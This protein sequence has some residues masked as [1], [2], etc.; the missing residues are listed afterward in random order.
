[1]DV[2]ARALPWARVLL[3][4]AGFVGIAAALFATPDAVTRFVVRPGTSLDGWD[5]DRLAVL[6]LGSAVGGMTLSG[7]ALGLRGLIEDRDGVRRPVLA[8]LPFVAVALI[9]GFKAVFGAEH[10]L[11]LMATREDSLV[12][13]LTFFAYAVAGIVAVGSSGRFFATGRALEGTLYLGLAF[14]LFGVAG[15]EI[16]WG[17]RV[18][19]IATPEAFADNLQGELTLHNLPGIQ[20]GLND[21]YIAVGLF[22][23]F[24]WLLVPWADRILPRGLAS[25]VAPSWWLIGYFLPVAAIYLVFQLTPAAEIH[26]RVYWDFFAM[27]DQELA[28]L[29]LALGFLGLALT[30]HGRLREEPF[31]Q[32]DPRV[33]RRVSALA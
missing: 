12:E 29:L 8:A 5:L 9:L 19:G 14:A 26:G 20:L 28:E 32:P 31:T 33:A 13:W 23:A 3:G 7:V 22:G 27:G 6:R 18:F 2:E 16:S 4:I 21:A 17:Q 1:M 15:E 11:Y 10:P 30:T 24:A 25:W